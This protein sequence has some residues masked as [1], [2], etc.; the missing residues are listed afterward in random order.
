MEVPAG[1]PQSEKSVPASYTS[2]GE[3]MKM[4]YRFRIE[5]EREADGRWIAEISSLPGVM[6]YGK[7]KHDAVRLVR[8][9]A[10]RVFEERVDRASVWR[11]LLIGCLVFVSAIASGQTR[12]KKSGLPSYITNTN[13]EQVSEDLVS[14]NIKLGKS[15]YTR[16]EPITVTF[17]LVAGKN[18]TYLP[19]YFRDWIDTCERGFSADVFT[20]D[21][22]L[23]DPTARGC[24]GGGFHSGDDTAESEFR[25][26]IYLRP[27]ETRSWKTTIKTAAIAPGSYIVIAEYL[28]NVYM[29]QEVSNLPKVNGL[30]AKG[31]VFAKPVPMKIR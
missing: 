10:M 6:V 24:G 1:K 28:S 16:G 27:G 11:F 17:R 14:L 23:A 7:T 19:N 9:L 31:K 25:N 3:T 29:I 20:K 13:A 8:V 15:T 30:M 4:S 2:I 12:P 18:G 5:I 26:F 22:R 21:G